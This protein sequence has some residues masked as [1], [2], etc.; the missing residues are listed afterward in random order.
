MTTEATGGTPNP[1]GADT[2]NTNTGGAPSGES[3]L[4]NGAPNTTETKTD[5]QPADAAGKDGEGKADGKDGTAP[6]SYEFKAPEGVA[7]DGDAVKEFSA[8]AKEL[9]L[10]PE[11][12]QR[13]VDV[14]VKMQQKQAERTAET[15]KGWAEQ[16]KTDKEFG[17][18]NLQQNLAVAQKAID[19]FGSKELKAMLV[20]S[21]LG[22]HPELIRFAFNAGKAISEGAFIKAGGR[23]STSN[24]E[25]DTAKKLYPNMN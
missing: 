20:E 2:T 11:A 4:T 10:S 5:G 7:L 19:T 21:G 12:A 13:A 3:L 18:D 17:G 16:S 23:T 22:N 24:H 1:A 25:V 6:E 15:V 8:L 14:A 9:K